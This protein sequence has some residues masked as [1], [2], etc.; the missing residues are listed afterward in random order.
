MSSPHK[1]NSQS[2]PSAR[3]STRERDS[4]APASSEPLVPLD[5]V[6]VYDEWF[7]RV[8]S[9]VHALG[10]PEADQYD[11]VQDVFLIV[12]RRLAHFDGANLAGWLY[13]IARRRVRDFRRLFWIRHLFAHSVPLSDDLS[14]VAPGPA[15]SLETKHRVRQLDELLSVLNPDQRAAFVLLEVEGYSG[16]EIAE[17][18]GVPVNTVWARIHKARKKLQ[19]G[20]DKAGRDRRASARD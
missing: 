4:A 10:T 1:G 9:W 20:L 7:E 15:D 16:K 6:T 19:A 17:L 12:H 2:E 18:Q 8:A 14:S 3:P 13:Q 5:F 11:L